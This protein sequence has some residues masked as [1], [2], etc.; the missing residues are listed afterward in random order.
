MLN[1]RRVLMHPRGWELPEGYEYV[2]FVR[3]NENELI[4]IDTGVGG[5]HFDPKT[6][7][8]EVKFSSSGGTNTV[9]AAIF[10]FR[11]SNASNQFALFDSGASIALSNRY[12]TTGTNFFTAAKGYVKGNVYTYKATTINNKRTVYID[13]KETYTVTTH[14]T[15]LGH[16]YLFGCNEN[17]SGS[18]TNVNGIRTIYYCKIWNTSTLV[19]DF[20]AVR[21]IE[22]G[23]VGFFDKITNQFYIS[24]NG[25]H[26]VT[27]SYTR[28]MGA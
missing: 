25:K 8:I 19:R 14:P 12:G 26:F 22:D 15:K 1:R 27:Q 24:P 28:N 17:D 21:R 13:G 11:V 2:P 3:T 4:W 20:V 18:V 10:G 23:E 9:S 5:S 7:D 16:I 6:V